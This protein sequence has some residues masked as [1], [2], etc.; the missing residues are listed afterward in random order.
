MSNNLNANPIYYDTDTAAM[1]SWRGDQT[2]NTGNLPS[3]NQQ[4]SGAVTR[5]WGFRV[6]KIAIVAT[7]AVTGGT[8]VIVDPKDSTEL[9]RA[10]YP[11]AASAAAF[12]PQEYDFEAM[13]VAWRDFALTGIT[14]N[15][16]AVKIW[17]RP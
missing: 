4:Y 8:V 7:G 9:F 17:Y 12:T 15:N 16:V 13:S 3:T 1:H 5:Q 2:L 10:N 11:T 14:G 6:S